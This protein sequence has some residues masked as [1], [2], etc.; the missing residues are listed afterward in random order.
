MKLT[1]VMI[2]VLWLGSFLSGHRSFAQNLSNQ[3]NWITFSALNDSLKAN[4][5]PV[6]INFYADWCVV[7]K[8][9]EHTTYKNIRVIE[10]LNKNYYAVKMNVETKDTIFFGNQVFV[11]KRIKKINPVHQI[12]LLMA[13]R[14]NRPFSLPAIVLFDKNFSATARYFQFLDADAM[15]KILKNNPKPK[16]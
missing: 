7:C 1:Q 8:E 12:A 13:S 16:F 4:P 3:I 5:K 11:N 2:M 15:E 10:A 14:K 9:M 6:L